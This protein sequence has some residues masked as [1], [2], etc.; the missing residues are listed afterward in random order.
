M[1]LTTGT[2]LQNGKYILNATL[3]QGG[4]GITYRATHTYLGQPVVIKTLNYSWRYHTDFKKFG[5]EFIAEA[6]RVTKCQ[7]P[8]IVKVLDFFEE[9]NL[10]FIVMEYIP[11][12]TLDE[13]IYQQGPLSEGIAINY[14]RQI[15]SAL[16]V[17]HENGL[18]HRD[19]KPHNI[20]RRSG[21]E[22]VVLIDFGIAREF[23]PGVTQTHTGFMSEGYA[24]IEQY[25]PQA[26]RTPAIDVY[27]LA[28]T[29]YSLVTA[30]APIA[31][32]L[33]DR[34]SLPK[35]RQL[36]PYLSHALEKA[37][38]QGLEME[39]E[40]RPQTVEK[41]L[42]ILPNINPNFPNYSVTV[43]N[44]TFP[45]IPKSNNT[46]DLETIKQEDNISS[47][48]RSANSNEAIT[49][50]NYWRWM[51]VI[52][53][54]TAI[55]AAIGGIGLGLVYRDRVTHKSPNIPLQPSEQNFPTTT[56]WPGYT[57][58]ETT[59]ENQTPENQNTPKNNPN[60]RSEPETINK[61]N[62]ENN[63]Q[64]ETP[65]MPKPAVTIS[66]IPRSEPADIQPEAPVPAA[67]KQPE[68]PSSEWRDVDIPAS[69]T[70]NRPGPETSPRQPEPNF[71]PP[72]NKNTN[73]LPSVSS[74][75]EIPPAL[76][77]EPELPPIVNPD[78]ITPP[79]NS[80]KASPNSE[81]MPP[82]PEPAPVPRQQN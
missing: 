45:L 60:P 7:H 47:V 27:A 22:T 35:P 16:T 24:P 28:A 23:T 29:L 32:S 14:I 38:L 46:E 11:G 79:Q 17:V 72:E 37:I 77:P 73:P 44:A 62:Q 34:I 41:W 58:K 1:N 82:F 71:P 56:P 57:P 4:F 18:L 81:P 76:I 39:A 61:E 30:K 3:G 49:N 8:N 75:K 43:S 78:A 67:G 63:I 9:N 50:A 25:L 52:F 68:I 2:S 5:Q 15:G 59:P 26:K 10:P 33:R 54:L 6:R 48:T 36:Q 80:P 40:K 19:V 55:I 20:V 13:I 70:T 65:V 31:A 74:P 69:N 21:S 53:G 64:P 12:V 51:P 42:E 66:P